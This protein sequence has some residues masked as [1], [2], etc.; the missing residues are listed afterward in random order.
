MS[1]RVVKAVVRAGA[2]LGL[3]LG[4]AVSTP[5]RAQV[6]SGTIQGTV[7][8]ES[9]AV[10]PGVAVTL[11]NQATGLTR[12]TVTDGSGAFRAP[13][14]PLGSWSVSAALSGF[15]TLERKGLTLTI[16][17]T[18][19]I[20]LTLKV[21]S[22]QELVEVTAEAPLIEPTRTQ[23][24]STV[25]AQ[26]VANLPVNGRNFID[27]VLTTPG[28]TRDVRLGDISF[29]GQRGTL[30][31]LIIDGAD[32]NNTFFGQTLGRTGSG[33][34]PY[35]FSQDAVQEFQV[36]RNAY[37]AE[38]GRAGGAVINVVTKSGSNVLHGSI[39][40]FYRDKRLNANSFANK[41][42]T[43]QRP[44]SPY[45]FDQFG[46]SLGGPLVKDRAFFF[47]SYDG[48]R[49]TIPNEISLAQNL[50]TVVVPSDPASQAGFATLVTKADNWERRQ[51]QDVFLARVDWQVDPKHRLTMRYNHQN[52]T[53]QNFENGGATNAEEHTGDSLVR[54]RTLNAS[55]ASVFSATLFNEFRFQWARDQEPGLANSSAPEATVRQGGRTL[56][57]IGRNFFSPRETT[58]KRF[59]FADTLTFVRGAHQ[60][61]AG[62]DVNRDQILNFFPGNFSGAYTF[63]S[64][65]AFAS[66]RPSNA[67]AGERYVQA[68]AGP[69]TSGATTNPDITEFAAFVQDE[70]R[71]EDVDRDAGPALRRAVVRA[72]G[73]QEPRRAVGGGRHRHELPE[74]GQEQPGAAP[75]LCLDAQLQGGGARRLRPVLRPHALDHGGHGPLE[76]RH[77]RADGHVH[78]QPRADLSEFLRLP[79]HGHRA[80][81][82]DHLRVRQGLREPAGASGQPGRRIRPVARL[83]DRRQLP[84]RGRAQAA[85]LARPERGRAGRDRHP[86]TGRRQRVDPAVPDGPAVL[87][88]RP[89]H[90]V[91]E[92]R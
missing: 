72:A 58:I 65:S 53:G 47:V 10:L 86:R 9:G 82:S 60:L 64:L 70:W 81:A 52:F 77:Q 49:N 1:D 56:L 75:G 39:F 78:G 92:Q 71:V 3:V 28:V 68:F 51:D 21:A 59:Q 38:Y 5:S 55:L 76:Q 27:F 23:Q 40:E 24:A 87:Q 67:A 89:H 16:G 80:A 73:G 6:A 19:T 8:D 29:A 12:E 22:A 18:L 44:K 4:L 13:L 42:V 2:L 50:G 79:A 15:A 57:T 85:T 88:L 45:H 48:Q 17:E 33:R 63:S 66:G 43:P 26:A 11:R 35:Q 62:V 84:V 37:S 34:A 20:D 69:G 41:I 36:N 54:T 61:K 46:G 14:L 90:P 25:G 83:L 74:D 7:S 30:N 31:S 91:R 32:N